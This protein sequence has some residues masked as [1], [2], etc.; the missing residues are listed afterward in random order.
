MSMPD[1]S[2]RGYGID[3]GGAPVREEAFVNAFLE[4]KAAMTV[5]KINTVSTKLRDLHLQSLH[6]ATLYCLV[7][8]FQYWTQHC[9][10]RCFARL[11][12][13]WH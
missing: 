7:P 1:G 3:V 12:W 8:M 10:P 2:V 11:G 13:L 6:S 9:Y 4:L 5:S